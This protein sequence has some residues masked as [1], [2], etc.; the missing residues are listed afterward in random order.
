MLIKKATDIPSSEI[1]SEYAYRNRRQFLQA[2][3]ATLGAAGMGAI[4]PTSSF[5]S[6]KYDTDE[7]RTPE[8]DVISY[9]NYYEFGTGK[10]EPVVNAKGFKMRPWTI[11]VSGMVKK[12]ATYHLDDL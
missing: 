11:A 1:T 4:L 6:S 10:D 9:N 3:A 5:A 8:K 12:P 7:M 2:A